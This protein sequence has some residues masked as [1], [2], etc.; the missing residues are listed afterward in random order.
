MS[1]NFRATRV[2]DCLSILVLGDVCQGNTSPGQR[3]WPRWL[4]AAGHPSHRLGQVPAPGCGSEKPE[5]MAVA[6]SKIQS[7]WLQPHTDHTRETYSQARYRDSWVNAHFLMAN[8]KTMYSHHINK[9]KTQ[10]EHTVPDFLSIPLHSFW[11]QH[12]IPLM[13]CSDLLISRFEHY[14]FN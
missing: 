2:Y 10:S 3:D 6:K 11:H 12:D 13:S 14:C 1:S 8:L 7:H 9:C 5:E 4:S